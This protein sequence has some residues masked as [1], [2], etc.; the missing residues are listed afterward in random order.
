MNDIDRLFEI[1]RKAEKEV[2][3]PLSDSDFKN[4]AAEFDKNAS[5]SVDKTKTNYSKFWKRTMQICSVI[6]LAVLSFVSMTD[7]HD[8]QEKTQRISN[9]SETKNR[10]SRDLLLKTELSEPETPK[11]ITV[12]KTRDKSPQNETKQ[13]PPTE[14]SQ[15]NEELIV[16]DY[17]DR[18]DIAK[19]DSELRGSQEDN[20]EKPDVSTDEPD[21]E[22]ENLIRKLEEAENI[23]RGMKGD[24]YKS[25]KNKH[26]LGISIGPDY[27]LHNGSF[28][29]P[30]CLE[31]CDIVY[32][33]NQRL[34]YRLGLVYEYIF[35]N[36]NINRMSFI[37]KSGYCELRAFATVPGEEYPTVMD[38][39]Y[40]YSKTEHR[41]QFESEIAYVDFRYRVRPFKNSGFGLFAG[42]G[43]DYTI[44]SNYTKTFS[45]TNPQ[46]AQFKK[47]D[48]LPEGAY[49]TPDKRT[50]VLEEGNN[51]GD[52][53][54]RFSAFGGMLWDFEIGDK[55]FIS[56][57]L[58]YNIGITT[59]TRSEEW[60][61]EIIRAG[62]DLKF[63]F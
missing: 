33:E 3:L 26:R 18:I 30:R 13:I 58:D 10:P 46:N 19:N 55:F 4:M 20:S 38:E 47:N 42:L 43:Y 60:R 25:E 62:I 22:K 9:E 23:I 1:A 31:D 36:P 16:V 27:I 32:S 40:L 44:T 2:Q 15:D 21:R 35:G 5:I 8:I 24:L 39:L 7:N 49:F 52:R 29:K 53:S 45:I 37:V 34:G 41:Y 28:A 17:S 51:S 48:N 54:F 12:I 63:G 59:I 6:I 50:I 56:P 57:Y 11:H 61:L 14:Y